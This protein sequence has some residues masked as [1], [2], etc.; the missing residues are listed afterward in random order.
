MAEIAARHAVVLAT[1]GYE[2]NATHG[3]RPRGLD[4]LGIAISTGARRRRA[5][6]GDRNRRRLP[7][8]AQQHAAVS[9]ASQFLRQ[10]PPRT[11]HPARR[12]CRT[13]Q[14][15]HDG[16]ESRAGKRF[17]DE[18]YF[19]GMVPALRLF[20][21][22]TH[23]YPNMPCFLIF[24][25]QYAA[26]LF[27]CGAPEGAPNSAV[28]HDRADTIGE[29]ARQARRRCGRA[30]ADDSGPLQRTRARRPRSGFSSWRE[31]VADG[32]GFRRQAAAT[33]VSAKSRNRHSTASNC[34]RPAPVLLAF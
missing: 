25:S 22:A 15:T 8:L 12:D 5:D 33:R 11:A 31:G 14:P 19:Q 1:G 10:R 3:H 9:R 28:G 29:L 21:P 18:A 24:N 16:G 13:V 26:G 2:S 34:I 32:T 7:P 17:A 6:A 20:D 30:C 27:V 4:Q 23:T